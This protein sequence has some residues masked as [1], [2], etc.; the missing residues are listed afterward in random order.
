MARAV[1]S[2]AAL[3]FFLH[4]G[5]CQAP[6]PPPIYAFNYSNTLSDGAVLQRNVS[7]ALFGFGPVFAR[8]SVSLAANATGTPLSTVAGIIG[9]DGTWRVQLPP[10]G[11]G[12]PF[13]IS[14]ALQP[15]YWTPPNA[16]QTWVLQNVLFGD[17]IVCGGQ[18]SCAW[19]RN[20]GRR[21]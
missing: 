6:S 15:G 13:V 4:R 12:G 3:S 21:R 16:T 1:V 7:A 2:A 8:F 14:G 18:V 17:V 11:A 19:G 10:Q 20:Q 5:A 9:S